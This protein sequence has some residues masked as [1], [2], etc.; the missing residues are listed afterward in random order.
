MLK[1]I[2]LFTLGAFLLLENTRAFADEIF[3]N[4]MQLTT[5]KEVMRTLGNPHKTVGESFKITVTN[6][7]NKVWDDYKILFEN[8]LGS[9]APGNVVI[10]GGSLPSHDP[11]ADFNVTSNQSV[12]DGRKEGSIVLYNGTLAP[13]GTLTIDVLLNFNNK[14]IISGQPSVNGVYATPEPSSLFLLG[15][16][17]LALVPVLR[18]RLGK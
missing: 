5:A 6:G 7:T 12:G 9:G 1:R 18:R 13:G 2:L 14:V 16:G 10:V 3:I 17:V 11:F 4:F 8:P 15:S